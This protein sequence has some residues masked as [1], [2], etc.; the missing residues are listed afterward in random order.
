MEKQ[1]DSLETLG[2][3]P[4]EILTDQVDSLNRSIGKIESHLNGYVQNVNSSLSNLETKVR[5]TLPLKKYNDIN[6]KVQTVDQKLDLISQSRFLKDLG[7]D[8][9]ESDLQKLGIDP[10]NL[11]LS[12]EKVKALDLDLDINANMDFVK[13]SKIN[14]PDQEILDKMKG[15]ASKA[16][17][18]TE[19]FNA[20]NI[21]SYLEQQADLGLFNIKE[22]KELKKQEKIIAEL[23]AE[24]SQYTQKLE[25]AT[26]PEQLKTQG[27]NLVK[28]T[29]KE[30]FEGKMEVVQQAQAQMAKY[31][32]HYDNVQSIKDLPKRPPNRMK[33]KPLNQRLLYGLSLTPYRTSEHVEFDVS[34]QVEFRWTGKLNIGVGGY[35]R[36]AINKEDIRFEDIPA[37]YGFRSFASFAGY[38]KF[39]LYGCVDLYNGLKVQPDMTWGNRQWQQGYLLGIGRSYK[40]KKNIYGFSIASLD[41]NKLRSDFNWEKYEVRFGVRMIIRKNK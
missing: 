3:L 16:T 8:L 28:S 22:I 40:I 12:L 17:K 11:S 23:Q 41:L 14:L 30:H 35:Y 21:K 13:G 2:H 36:V 20:K 1:I 38:K 10:P 34:P 24:M 27:V 5:D 31:K 4:Q 26:N 6:N 9:S 15:Y 25:M 37:H 7:F 33:G 18:Q 19:L 39:Y 32:K 29:A